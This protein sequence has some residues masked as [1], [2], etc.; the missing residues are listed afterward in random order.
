MPSQFLKRALSFYEQF[1]EDQGRDR[2]GIRNAGRAMLRVGEIELQLERV[3]ASRTWQRRTDSEATFRRAERIFQ[4]L[5]IAAPSDPEL[6]H[7]LALCHLRLGQ[8]VYTEEPCRQAVAS[9]EA[10]VRADP[11]NTTYQCELGYSLHNLGVWCWNH[12]PEE[13]EACLSRALAIQEQLV[14][15]EP[16]ELDDQRELGGT[17]RDIGNLRRDTARLDGALPYYRRALTIHETLVNRTPSFPSFRLNLA[18]DCWE[19]GK[20][21]FRLG[22]YDEAV[23][24]EIRAVTLLQGLVAEYPEADSYRWYQGE[25]VSQLSLGLVRAGLPR[26]IE[27]ALSQL[28]R[29]LEPSKNSGPMSP[30]PAPAAAWGQA[31]SAEQERVWR[32]AI[33]LLEMAPP[34]DQVASNLAH[35]HCGL[36]AI[37]RALGRLRDADQEVHTAGQIYEG[38]L[39]SRKLALEREPEGALLIGHYARSLAIAP[40]PRQ[41]DLSQALELVRRS[42]E[43]MPEDHDNRNTLG[44]VEYR[45]GHWDAAIKALDESR[46]I[47]SYRH[48]ASFDW[49]F[50]AMAHWQRGEKE[51]ARTCYGHAVDGINRMVPEYYWDSPCLWE[52]EAFRAEAEELIRPAATTNKTTY[53]PSGPVANP[54]LTETQ[55]REY[56]PARAHSKAAR[57]DAGL[58]PAE[59]TARAEHYTARAVEFLG[60]ARK[61]GYFTNPYNLTVLN[62]E[63]D[64]DPLRPRA[65]FQALLALLMDQGFPAD[66]FAGL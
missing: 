4:D 63:T 11:Q 20:L 57:A 16:E 12:R 28:D 59:R 54:Q 18:W 19:Q 47:D 66:P 55:P 33:S 60:R 5:L 36:G 34:S 10:L 37:L 9:F 56:E 62:R 15:V 65:D 52:M 41:R 43:Q 61:A 29:D 22:R 6:R 17:L 25:S 48:Y 13:A 8:A 7:D 50:L 35:A 46:A 32:R 42:L 58:A 38:V 53:Q 44:V 14:S 31:G 26:A 21:M 2:T 45:L 24:L 30:A 39:R 51:Q 27:T 1:A 49:I 40:D 3:T 23:Q 64:F